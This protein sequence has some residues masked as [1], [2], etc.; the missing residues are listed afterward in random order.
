MKLKIK[1]KPT[2]NIETV[3]STFKPCC[4]N[5]A[6]FIVYEADAEVARIPNPLLQTW[7]KNTIG[8]VKNSAQ[9]ERQEECSL[10]G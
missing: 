1:H 8:L 9:E 2:G 3:M 4:T 6:E 10:R 5:G 7:V